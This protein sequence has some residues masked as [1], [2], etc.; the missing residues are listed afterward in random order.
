LQHVVAK[1]AAVTGWLTFGGGGAR[2]GATS[3]AVGP[4]KASWFSPLQGTVTAQPLVARNVPRAGDTTVY[5]ATA[6]G[7]VYALAAN[8]YI[9]WRVDLGRFTAPDCPQIPDGWGVT[10]TPVIDP[11]TR[12]LYVAD[13]FGRL[14]ALDL[15]TGAERAGWPVVLYRDYKRELVWGALL[16]EKGSVYAGTGSYCDQPMEGRLIRV[17]LVDGQVSSWTTV[18]ASLGGGGGIWGWGG[19]AYSAK[20]DAIFALTGNAFEGGS[21]VG[22]AFTEAAGYGEH[23]VELS[24]DLD[25]VASDDPGLKGFTDLDFV[26]SPVVADTSD[27]GEIVA[28]QA[29]NG[30]LFGWNAA[31]VAAGPA[32]SLALQKADPQTPLLT[33]PTWSPKLRSFYVATASTLARIELDASCKPR[34][35]WQTPLG[36][37]TLYPSPTVAGNTVWVGLPVKDLSGKAEALLGIDARTGRILVRKPIQGVS[38]AP[39]SVLAGTLF[40]ASMHGLNAGGFVVDRG[41]PASRL[42]R[43]RSQVDARHQW[44]SREDGVYSTDDGGKHWRKIYPRY[45]TRVRRL[46]TTTGLISVGSPAPACGCATRQLST[47]DGGKT[48]RAAAIGESFVGSGNTVYWWTPNGLYLAAPGLRH[49]TRVARTEDTIVSGA[50]V[51]G[52]VAA[53]VDRPR[54]SPQ[55][56]LAQGSATRLVTLPSGPTNSVVR[57]IAM[58]GADLVVRGTYVPMS[59]AA[60]VRVDWSS[61]D[62]GESWTFTPLQSAGDHAAR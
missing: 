8:G 32:W 49:S 7:F 52:G 43:Y 27:C 41:R 33:Q 48:W 21:N 3:S 6:S 14:H 54:L 11:A 56:I 36:D 35:A 18:P 38:F 31:D 28:A 47:E 13:A 16:L 15:S 37:A 12:T 42:G 17:S 20:Q 50:L 5:V 2:L 24:R 10:G 61:K 1:P 4:L 40:L 55:V 57:T 53:L 34:I 29:K 59:A 51:K 26:G 58:S 39:P 23:L 30:M 19:V 62:G 22:A 60:P 9:R 44:Q 45:A 46:S 25:V